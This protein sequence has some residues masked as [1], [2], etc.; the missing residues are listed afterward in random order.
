MGCW[1]VGLLWCVA[2]IYLSS[3]SYFPDS[4][5]SSIWVVIY[6]SL[7]TSV[8][9]IIWTVGVDTQDVEMSWGQVDA[10]IVSSTGAALTIRESL[11][12]QYVMCCNF[13]HHP[14]H[15]HVLKWHIQWGVES[16]G[17]GKLCLSPWLGSAVLASLRPIVFNT[18]GFA[19]DRWLCIIPV[20]VAVSYV[21]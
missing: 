14:L 11:S 13:T 5:I 7:S 6:V 10:L 18:W 20:V 21:E 19:Y 2:F 9:C 12:L 16:Q 4:I 15:S 8:P 1:G 3:P 17:E